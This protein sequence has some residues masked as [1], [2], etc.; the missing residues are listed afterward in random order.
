MPFATPGNQ[1]LG[2]PRLPFFVVFAPL[3]ATMRGTSMTF[4]LERTVTP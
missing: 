4:L 3:L 1:T 2:L